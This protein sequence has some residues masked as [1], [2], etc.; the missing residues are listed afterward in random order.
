MVN[1]KNFCHEKPSFISF[2]IAYLCK[3]LA[4]VLIHRLFF[5]SFAYA[6]DWFQ[7]ITGLTIP[8]LKLGF[9]IQL[10]KVELDNKEYQ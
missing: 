8:Q 7:S 6:R 10:L 4:S 5:K 2:T 9:M 1:S 3:Q